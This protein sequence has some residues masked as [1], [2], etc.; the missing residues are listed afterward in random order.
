[1]QGR[2]IPEELVPLLDSGFGGFLGTAS[3][4]QVPEATRVRGARVDE[5][6]RTL[7]VFVPTVQAARA[8]EN[9]RVNPRVAFMFASVITLQAAQIKGETIAIRPCTDEERALV[10]R[11]MRAFIEAVESIGGP[12]KYLGRHACWPSHAIEI[13]VA[14]VFVQT[15]GPGSGRPWR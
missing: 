8:L 13:R 2:E 1:V 9:L 4:D 3:A 11:H 10:E 6:R 5:S 14:E 7:T 12:A 15:P